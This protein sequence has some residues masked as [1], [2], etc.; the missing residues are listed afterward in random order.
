MSVYRA[1]VLSIP[2][3]ACEA[4]SAQSSRYNCTSIAHILYGFVMARCLG[5]ADAC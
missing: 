4:G 2:D 5:S 3:N 1:E